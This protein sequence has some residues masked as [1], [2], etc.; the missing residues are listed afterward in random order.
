M[1]HLT[2]TIVKR[3]MWLG[4]GTATVMGLAMLLALTIGT[5]TTALA[6]VPGNPF[7]L[8]QVNA[9]NAAS[10]ISGNFNN[11][12]LRVTNT[13]TG[14]SATALNLQVE[15]GK[16]PMRVNSTTEVQGLNVD[17]LDSKNSSDFLQEP[18]DREDFLPDNTYTEVEESFGPGSGRLAFFSAFC[19]EGDIAL[20]GGGADTAPG[21][22]AQFVGSIPHQS[23]SR[24]WTAQFIDSDNGSRFSA[25]VRCADF[26]PLR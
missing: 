24:G 3:T 15:P 20:G 9:I 10:A 25:T 12:M 1:K 22:G 21:S 6:A 4:R 16:P 14:P 7:K 2:K 13:S 11:A 19:D 5:A 8:G 17:S 26:P 18:S 23:D